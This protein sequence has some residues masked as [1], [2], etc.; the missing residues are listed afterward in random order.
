[1]GYQEDRERRSVSAEPI[2]QK[3]PSDPRYGPV[4]QR[5]SKYESRPLSAG[6]SGLE[7]VGIKEPELAAF[8]LDY[9]G[10]KTEEACQKYEEY[11]DKKAME[12]SF[13]DAN[14][15][16]D[17]LKHQANIQH[18]RE[19]ADKKEYKPLYNDTS[20]VR[21]LGDVQK[22]VK[23]S[24]NMRECRSRWTTSTSS[25]EGEGL[26][27]LEL[28]RRLPLGLACT[29]A[30]HCLTSTLVTPRCIVN[31]VLLFKIFP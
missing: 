6:G 21:A 4:F 8:K 16:Q 10:K 30:R 9:I 14:T 23:E 7:L 18:M 25:I 29:R 28:M 2:L 15:V 13:M 19:L 24:E 1:M 27:S 5:V 3:K 22:R 11:V 17:F 12:Q 20:Y 26:R 31:F